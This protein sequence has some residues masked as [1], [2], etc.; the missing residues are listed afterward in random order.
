ME[1]NRWKKKKKVVIQVCYWKWLVISTNYY[2]ELSPITQVCS[3]LTCGEKNVFYSLPYAFIVTNDYPRQDK[4][5]RKRIGLWIGYYID[6][7]DLP[8]NQQPFQL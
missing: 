7:N 5:L 6:K 8:L 2:K 3:N 4:A 1:I